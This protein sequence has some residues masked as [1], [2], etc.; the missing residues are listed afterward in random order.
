MKRGRGR[1]IDSI[2]RT[3]HRRR[4]AGVRAEA[5]HI[6]SSTSRCRTTA[7]PVSPLKLA[8]STSTLSILKSQPLSLFVFVRTWRA[9][10]G[11]AV[12]AKVTRDFANLRSF[13]A[14][15]VAAG[16]IGPICLLPCSSSLFV[17]CTSVLSATSAVALRSCPSSRPPLDRRSVVV[18]RAEW[19][20]EIYSPPWRCRLRPSA[21]LLARSA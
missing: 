13:L 7:D 3:A 17:L 16:Y 5:D 4:A 19:A 21:P 14:Q 18:L 20:R 1:P 6:H 15:S 9:H 11:P 8:L 2:T 12:R 10:R